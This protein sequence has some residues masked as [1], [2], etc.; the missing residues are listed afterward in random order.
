MKK[1]LFFVL[2]ILVSAASFGQGLHDVYKGQQTAQPVF[3][4]LTYLGYGQGDTVSAINKAILD[5]SAVHGVVILPEGNIG[6]PTAYL[7]AS[8]YK[9]TG[10]VGASNV[11]LRGAGID[12]TIIIQD[13]PPGG[14]TFDTSTLATNTHWSSVINCTNCTNFKVENLS[15]NGKL[16]RQI[17]HTGNPYTNDVISDTARTDG[18]RIVGGK[19][20]KIY[21][22]RVDSIQFYGINVTNGYATYIQNPSIT[23]SIQGGIYFVGMCNNSFV[24]GGVVSNNNCDNVRLR[25]GNITLIGTEISW[26]KFNPQA[27][28]ANFAGLYVENDVGSLTTGIIASDL[29]IHDN[30]SYAVDCFNVDTTNYTLTGPT[31]TMNGG[32]YYNNANGGVQM[33]MQRMAVNNVNIY[34]NGV[35]S[36]GRTDPV[37][38]TGW[39]V[40]LHGPNSNFAA[41]TNNKFMNNPAVGKQL[42]GIGMGSPTAVPFLDI[43]GNTWTGGLDLLAI[44]TASLKGTA[45]FNTYY[46]NSGM[47]SNRVVRS[48]WA[49]DPSGAIYMYN[50]APGLGGIASGVLELIGDLDAQFYGVHNSTAT[51]S[52]YLGDVSSLGVGTGFRIDAGGFGS[53]IAARRLGFWDFQVGAFRGIMNGGGDFIWGGVDSVTSGHWTMQVHQA[54]NG[55]TG[56]PAV[57]VEG[58]ASGSTNG[59]V[60]AGF[61]GRIKGTY[62]PGTSGYSIG[63]WGQN[64]NVGGNGALSSGITVSGSFGGYF[65]SNGAN[66]GANGTGFGVYGVALNST[67]NV[68]GFFD[69]SG[70]QVNASNAL[71]GGIIAIAQNPNASASEF[72]GYFGLN[73]SGTPTY[74]RAVIIADNAS[75]TAV[76]IALFRRTGTIRSTVDSNGNF[77]ASVAGVGI[78]IK[79]GTN[80]MM[81]VGT[82]SGGTV[83]IS[84]TKVTANSRIMLTVQSLG[85]VSVTKA[86]GITAR[87]PGTSFVITSADATDTS[88]VAWEIFEPA[89]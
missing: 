43:H 60:Q 31:V 51:R 49:T 48:D 82:L 41:I 26:A 37:T 27:G 70:T 52:F 16:S 35:D 44:G 57:E 50:R 30:S 4:A 42:Y 19:F 9:P 7:S 53:G 67:R 34:N 78:L 17:N 59:Q 84:T 88:I 71:S 45:P 72:G 64:F 21:N 15:V 80:A 11:T 39:G 61:N 3:N 58:N 38:Y 5:A 65:S 79:E 73:A 14:S 69:A 56:S 20:N 74:G 1:L 83:T 68:G 87:T 12:Q 8:S 22:V 66:T 13:A 2:S 54:A 28:G 75:E 23:T 46:G 24:I 6:I 89:P 25:T 76:P 10:I 47:D 77:V 86:V 81:G 18:I 55:L 33:Q 36:L 40:I 29:R 63:I 32:M 62:A 85:T